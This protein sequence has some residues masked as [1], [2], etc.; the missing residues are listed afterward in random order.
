MYNKAET[1]LLGG[2][3]G[4]K[5]EEHIRLRPALAKIA[6]G[7][8]VDL[9]GVS[10]LK[11]VKKVHWKKD[12]VGRFVW[13]SSEPGSAASRW[14]GKKCMPELARLEI[15]VKSPQPRYTELELN[16]C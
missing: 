10:V 6:G 2:A 12:V 8:F 14:R 15:T 9:V 1:A 7:I 13:E 11:T 3:A 4:R 5:R 16:G